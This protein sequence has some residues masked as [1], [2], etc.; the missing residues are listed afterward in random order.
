[1]VSVKKA[2]ETI[3]EDV[4]D[5]I[6]YDDE[7][8]VTDVGV[9]VRDGVVTLTG[10]LESFADRL[11]AEQAAFRVAGVRAVA[12]D[13][14][15]RVSEGDPDDTQIAETVADRLDRNVEVPRDSVQVRVQD[16]YVILRGEL[17]RYYQR[18]A[19]YKSAVRVKGARHV[20]NEITLSRQGASPAEVGESIERALTRN[21]ALDAESIRVRVDGSHVT[22]TGEVG[23]YSERRE[24]V[25][26]AWRTSGTAS[27]T[28]EITIRTS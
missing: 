22:L 21:A 3:Q 25:A 26:A 5:E 13:M 2:D 16:G 24:A 10:A 11:A 17:D 27:V 6:A 12:N 15:V 9:G 23:S 4:L 28:D 18:E 20:A 1:M 8:S 7:V 19:A 14:T